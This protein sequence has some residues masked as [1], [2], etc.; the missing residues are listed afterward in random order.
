MC[1][2][3]V[4]MMKAEGNRAEGKSEVEWFV[5]VGPDRGCKARVWRGDEDLGRIFQIVGC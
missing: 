5:D 2:W 1:F 3:G 4:E